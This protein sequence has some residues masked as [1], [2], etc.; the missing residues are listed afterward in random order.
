MTDVQ[1][2]T[3]DYFCN[4]CQRTF[5]K[6]FK[7]GEAAPMENVECV[8]CGCFESRKVTRGMRPNPAAAMA[9]FMPPELPT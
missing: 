4:N 2:Y 5:Q 6:S 3:V 7:F 1:M 8:V 9:P